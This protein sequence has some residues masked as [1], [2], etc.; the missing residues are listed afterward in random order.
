MRAMVTRGGPPALESLPVP[1]PARG[2]LLVRVR[3][4]AVNPR[5]WMIC[6]GRYPLQWRLPRGPLVLGSDFAGE[7]VAVGPGCQRLAPGERVHGM[8]AGQRF[9]AFAEYLAVAESVTARLPAALDFA[10]GAAMTLCGL[11]AW[12]ALHGEARLSAGQRVL[13][14]GASGG[15]GHL[16]VQLAVAAGVAVTGVCSSAN[17]DFVR[18][19]GASRVIDYRRRS[20]AQLADR[21]PVVFDTIGRHGVAAWRPRL[22]P[23]GVYVTTVPGPRAIAAS[24]RARLLPFGRRCRLVVVRASAKDLEALDALFEAGRLGV[25]IAA[26][27]PLERLPEALAASRSFRTRGKLVIEIAQSGPAPAPPSGCA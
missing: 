17:T 1:V 15:V 16:A 27:H 3:A 13:V 8:Q 10:Q 12:Q 22:E 9:G 26:S 20:P 6:E 19:L 21:W 2:E 25:T 24:L 18:G 4:A 23:G 11:T 14:V 7:V 5:D